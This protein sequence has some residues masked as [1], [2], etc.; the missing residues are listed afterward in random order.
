[1]TLALAA[2][3][4]PSLTQC[5]TLSNEV[6]RLS[7]RI[8]VASFQASV[9]DVLV[10]KALRAAKEYDVRQVLLA[11]GVAANKGLRMALTAAFEELDKMGTN[12][13]SY[14]VMHR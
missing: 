4:Q 13:S 14:K 10:T 2:L 1:M 7:R 8:S 6:K 9:I 3:N 11:G 12:Y 5:T